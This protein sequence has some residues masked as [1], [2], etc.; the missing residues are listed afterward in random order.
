[1]FH[2]SNDPKHTLEL[3][4]EWIKEAN[5]QLVEWI[6]QSFDLSLKPVCKRWM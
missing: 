2:K 1:M 3:I 4:W 6:F 5:I